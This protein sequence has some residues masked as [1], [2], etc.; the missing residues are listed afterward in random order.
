[1]TS[2]NCLRSDAKKRRELAPFFWIINVLLVLLLT[3][4]ATKYECVDNVKMYS[5]EVCGVS[6]GIY[7]I[8]APCPKFFQS[9]YP[10]SEAACKESDYY[11]KGKCNVNGAIYSIFDKREFGV[12]DGT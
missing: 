10:N 8:K 4:C 12:K 5:D 9:T 3:G 11:T 2:N 1:M 7:C 6:T